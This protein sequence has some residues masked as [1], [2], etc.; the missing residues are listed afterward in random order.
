MSKVPALETTVILLRHAEKLPWHQGLAPRKEIKATYVDDH[1][2]SC[3]GQERAHAL[4]GY[5]NHREE[6]QSIFRAAPLAAIIAQDVDTTPTPW[7]RSERPKQTVAP[8]ASLL[9][10]KG[11]E[12]IT[13]TKKQAAEVLEEI[14]SGRWRG[15][16][17]I[18]SWAHQQLPELAIALGVKREKV[19]AHWPG[20][21]FDVTWVVEPQATGPPSF[22]QYAQRLMYGDKDTVLDLGES[23]GRGEEG[24]E[25]ED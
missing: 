15:R 1:V 11:V 20:K 18:V 19:P 2:L 22:R 5:F 4:V 7:G 16:T 17:V 12:F 21:R 10:A 24:G 25:D 6:M 8:L 14:R 13:K 9:S 3:K 23:S